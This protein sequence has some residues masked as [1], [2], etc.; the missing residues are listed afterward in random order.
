MYFQAFC[1]SLQVGIGHCGRRVDTAPTITI[2]LTGRARKKS[3][4]HL[5]PCFR[6]STALIVWFKRDEYNLNWILLSKVSLSATFRCISMIN[7]HV[8][9][10]IFTSIIICFVLLIGITGLGPSSD[11]PEGF[12]PVHPHSPCIP[13]CK[14]RKK[15][16]K[17]YLL[18]CFSNEDGL[19]K[20]CCKRKDLF[21]N[22]IGS[23]VR[24]IGA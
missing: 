24:L 7:I 6:G 8:L 21:K 19:Q 16:E 20:S 9:L 23:S 5:W 1:G 2:V 3:S 11:Q 13:N 4:S 17:S 18:E 12:P 22:V 14:A 10:F 15:L